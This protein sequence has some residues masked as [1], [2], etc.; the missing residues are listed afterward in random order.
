MSTNFFYGRKTN[1]SSSFSLLYC[2]FHHLFPRNSLL[3]SA[4]LQIVHRDLA[5]RNVLLG[6]GYVAKVADF[7][8]ARD[9]YKYQ[10]Y[11]KKSEVLSCTYSLL[12]RKFEVRM[13]RSLLLFFM[14]PFKRPFTTIK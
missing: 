14:T 13:T 7:G 8:L 1:R 6:N 9:I 2:F 4:V 5:A 3:F 12:K 10:Q 11:V